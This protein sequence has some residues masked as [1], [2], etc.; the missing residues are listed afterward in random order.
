[1]KKTKES[2]FII[3]NG[4][5]T[6]FFVLILF[7]TMSVFFFAFAS[8]SSFLGAYGG[9]LGHPGGGGVLAGSSEVWQIILML[10]SLLPSILICAG[11]WLLCF[12]FRG[13]GEG[14]IGNLLLIKGA[15]AAQFVLIFALIAVIFAALFVNLNFVTINSYPLADRLTDGMSQTVTV[16]VL[17]A[18]LAAA[19]LLVMY[20][21]SILKAAN[22]VIKTLRTG[23]R[24]GFIPMPLII[25]NCGF[26]LLNIVGAGFDVNRGNAAA[27]AAA[28]CMAAFLLGT[29]A[30]L[31][32]VRRG[33]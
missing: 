15:V 11:L 17:F 7:Y 27:S 10:A 24:R 22:M 4:A 21:L 8:G 5:S 23:E 25:M 12:A 33:N 14:A 3:G 26:S 16:V 1:L 13:K 31:N 2:G 18:L 29:A 28:I 20:F 30:L 9:L 19:A 32:V 6:T